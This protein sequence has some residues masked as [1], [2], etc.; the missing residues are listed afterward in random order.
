MLRSHGMVREL[1]SE[2]RRRDYADEHPDLNPDFIF[3]LPG[4]NVRSTEINAV[5]GRSQLKRLDEDI[6]RRTENLRLFLDNL[7]PERLPDRLRDRG[8]QQLRLHADPAASRTTTLMRAGHGALRENG[9]EFRRGTAGGGNQLR[10]PYLRGCWGRT[11]GG[12]SRRRTTCISSASTSAT[13]RLWNETRSSACAT[14]STPSPARR[15]AADARLQTRPPDP[16]PGQPHP[17]LSVAGER[18]GGRREPGVGGADGDVLPAPRAVGR[19]HRRR[20][21]GADGG[22][23]GGARPRR[24]PGAGG[25]RGL[26]TPALR[27]DADHDGGRPGL[28]GDQAAG[29][30]AEGGP[31]RRPRRR[32]ARPHPCGRGSGLRRR[33]RGVAHAG[34]PG[35]KR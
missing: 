2:S 4:Y 18:A 5:I 23:G 14:C 34:R 9:V 13:I 11:P 25:G 32:P 17:G 8:K 7:D 15:R 10:Q 35:R 24:R 16:Q 21:G 19:A 22:S 30:G 28:L 33:R 26:R 12:H 1:D 31:R 27:L 3:A 20:G 29:A 6:R